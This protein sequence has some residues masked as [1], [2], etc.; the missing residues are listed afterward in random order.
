MPFQL[1]VEALAVG[2]PARKIVI[3]LRMP[4]LRRPSDIGHSVDQRLLGLFVESAAV[5]DQKNSIPKHDARG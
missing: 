3:A 5:G 1:E 4:D 2:G